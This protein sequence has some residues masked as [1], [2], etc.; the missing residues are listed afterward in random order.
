MKRDK[1]LSRQPWKS[2]FYLSARHPGSHWQIDRTLLP[3]DTEKV[4]FVS[5]NCQGIQCDK[6]RDRGGNLWG[7]HLRCAHAEQR[8][9]LCAWS[10]S[11]ILSR[12]DLILREFWKRRQVWGEKSPSMAGLFPCRIKLGSQ[13]SFMPGAYWF[14]II[15]ASHRRCESNIGREPIPII[16]VSDQEVSTIFFTS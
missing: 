7:V 3:P 2:Q 15:L 8:N 16:T 12:L 1:W 9:W 11:C 10:A 6:Q 5:S 4:L 14:F 13:F